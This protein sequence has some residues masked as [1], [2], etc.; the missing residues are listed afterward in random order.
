MLKTEERYEKETQQQYNKQ[1]FYLY[2][3]GTKEE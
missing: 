1:S 3:K 2:G